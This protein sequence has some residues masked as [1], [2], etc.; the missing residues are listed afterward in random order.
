MPV[1]ANIADSIAC[2][3][4]NKTAK[5]FFFWKKKGILEALPQIKSQKIPYFIG[6]K[7]TNKPPKTFKR[8]QGDYI[9][10]RGLG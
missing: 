7:L 1:S 8:G 5:K 2:N 10:L 4:K 6:I 9:P 3:R